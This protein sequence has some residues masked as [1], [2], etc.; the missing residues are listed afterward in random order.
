[1]NNVFLNDDLEEEVYLYQPEAF[2]DQDYSHYVCILKNAL[3]G[4][5]QASRAWCTKLSNCLIS[6]GF[7]SSQFYT[8][9]ILYND[10]VYSMVT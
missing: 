10:R 8:S 2:V 5:K 6:W 9:M 7:R 4:L 3:Y 1:M